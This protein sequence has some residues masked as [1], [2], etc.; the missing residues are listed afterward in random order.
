MKIWIIPC[1][2]AIIGSRGINPTQETWKSY[3][4]FCKAF[5]C[6]LVKKHYPR[7]VERG[8]YYNITAPYSASFHPR[9]HHCVFASGA[10]DLTHGERSSKACSLFCLRPQRWPQNTASEETKDWWIY[11][12]IYCIYRSNINM[13]FLCQLFI[14]TD[15]FLTRVF[16]VNLCVFDS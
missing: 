5:L 8:S 12:F 7:E 3:K 4:L 2:S 9:R 1:L 6:K 16:N 10:P 15:M 11:W 13:W 14:F